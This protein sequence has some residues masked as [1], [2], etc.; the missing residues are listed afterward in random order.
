M[1]KDKAMTATAADRHINTIPVTPSGSTTVSQ[2][3]YGVTLIVI[4]AIY[5]EI[6]LIQ[7]GIIVI[8]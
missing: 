7:R 6:I 2:K 1:Q 4:S 3:Y 5:H 8:F